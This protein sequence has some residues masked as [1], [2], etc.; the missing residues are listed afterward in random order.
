MF[1]EYRTKIERIVIRLLYSQMVLSKSYS[2]VDNYVHMR[3]KILSD[4]AEVFVAATRA[5]Y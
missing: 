4:T 1:N 3:A 5:V 2:L